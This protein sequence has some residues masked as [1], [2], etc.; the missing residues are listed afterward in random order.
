MN[1]EQVLIHVR[2]SPDGTVVEIG[3]RPWSLTGQSWFN[4]LNEQADATYQAL[5]GGRAVFR[6][7]RETIDTL[8]LAAVN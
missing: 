1:S 6:L 2:F 4:L 3:D 7:P 5:A 8:K